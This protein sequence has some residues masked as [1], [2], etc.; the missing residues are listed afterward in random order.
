ME[1]VMTTRGR[2]VD[3]WKD[4]PGS[5]HLTCTV[6][7]CAGWMVGGSGRWWVGG[8]IL[9]EAEGVVGVVMI[10]MGPCGKIEGGGG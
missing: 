7:G 10:G 6:M 3:R 1:G 2:R 5:L 4:V 8:Y 9:V